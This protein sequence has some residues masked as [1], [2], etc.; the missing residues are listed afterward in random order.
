MSL[1]KLRTMKECERALLAFVPPPR[2]Q[3]QKYTLG[4]IRAFMEAI[5]NPQNSYQVVH[6]AGTSGKTSTCYYTAALLSASGLKT[7]LTVSPHISKVSERIQINLL[8]ASDKLFASELGVFLDVVKEVAIDLTYFEVLMA[9]AYWFFGR[10]KV[11]VAVI[12]TGIG[13]LLDGSNVVRNPSKVCVLTDI[14][15]DHTALL[16]ETIPQIA[17]QKAGI[18]GED[19]DVFCWQQPPPVMSVFR[20]AAKAQ[21]AAF[22]VLTVQI[23]ALP[24]AMPLFQKRNFSLAVYAVTSL[25]KE[26]YHKELSRSVLKAA[27][28]QVIPA[29]M[30]RFKI[31]NTSVTLDGA[32]NPQKMQ[33]LVK[34]YLHIHGTT[35]LIVLYASIEGPDAKIEQTVA[36][37]LRLKPQTIILTS[38]ESLQ[39]MKKASIAPVTLQKI[40]HNAGFNDTTVIADPHKALKQLLKSKAQILVTGSLYLLFELRDDLLKR[41]N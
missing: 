11:D 24:S 23:E 41:A 28:K 37:L 18:I 6:V 13:G 39:D 7:G 26:K 27:A 32:H 8:P 10:Q 40:F 1:M 21:N 16:G 3:R 2:S 17:A 9:F 35:P 12:E 22:H 29:R 14:G 25:L 5:G 33:A 20:N 15:L 31:G 36:E 19:N 34:S 38:F 4:P 30:E